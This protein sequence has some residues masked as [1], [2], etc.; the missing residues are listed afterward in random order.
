VSNKLANEN[1][2]GGFFERVFGTKVEK[3]TQAHSV[4]LADQQVLYE[5]QSIK[6]AFY[7]TNQSS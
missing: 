1:S 6:A 7:S 2:G 3:A 4:L 5:L